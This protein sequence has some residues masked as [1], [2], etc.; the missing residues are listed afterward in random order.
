MQAIDPANAYHV[1]GVVN[2]MLVRFM[3]DTGAA[4]SLIMEDVKLEALRLE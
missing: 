1:D 4:V 2:N 3:V